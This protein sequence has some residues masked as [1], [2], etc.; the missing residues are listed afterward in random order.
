MFVFIKKNEHKLFPAQFL[1]VLTL[2]RIVFS[3]Q[4]AMG[5]KNYSVFCT[6]HMCVCMSVC[7]RAYVCV[8]VCLRERERERHYILLPP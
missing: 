8:C 2:F 1:F 5:K 7:L 3:K 4:V 6:V